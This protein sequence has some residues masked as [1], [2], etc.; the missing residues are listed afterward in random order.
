[1]SKK[2]VQDVEVRGKRAL[3]RVDFNVPV[4]D[5]GEITDDSRIRLS[6]PTINYLQ[7]HGASVI[8][9]S[10]FGRPGGKTV[11]KFR[12][13]GVRRRLGELLGAEVLDAGGPGGPQ[14][15]RVAASIKPGQVALIENL[16]FDP[17]EEANDAAFAKSL[18]ALADIYVDDAFAAAH[19][20]HASV[21]GVAKHLPAVA[22]L[23][24]AREIE[25]LGAAVNAS[26]RPAVAV[27][28]GAKV[29]DKIQVLTH[30]A[31]RMDSLLIGGGMVAAFFRAKGMSGGKAEVTPA[32]IAAAQRLLASGRPEVLT[33][34][35]VVV[36]EA[37]AAGVPALT[38]PATAVPPDAWILDI[39]PQARTAYSVE[40]ARA[41]S[42]IWNGPMGVFEW[43]QFAE[44]TTAIARA[45]A[46]N[47]TATT[48]VGGGSSV[49]VV[50]QLGLRDGFTHVSTGGGASLEF[51]EGKT[52]PGVAVLLDK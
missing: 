36:G 31:P 1:M 47:R 13:T 21:V 35:D 19:R 37:L 11:E 44:G 29:A 18:A 33:P 26:L 28:G 51:L 14:P 3:V 43:P 25:M 38:V 42:V 24:M 46:S 48:V 49:E 4:N 32:E 9:C 6:L 52:L 5:A 10:H 34:V 7:E 40:I 27:V 30:L 2:T 15:A 12:L 23:L 16:R 41:R 17:G 20:A 8:A 39:G 45:I 22:G 50:E